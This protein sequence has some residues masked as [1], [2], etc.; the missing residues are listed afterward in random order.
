MKSEDSILDKKYY[1]NYVW[2][3]FSRM[4]FFS[5]FLFLFFL[6]MTNDHYNVF[7]NN[8]KDVDDEDNIN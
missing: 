8:V 4:F 3:C 7:D 2:I 6:M 1:S 5:F